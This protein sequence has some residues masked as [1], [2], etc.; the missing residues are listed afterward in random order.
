MSVR[1]SVRPSARNS[2][3]LIEQISM[4]F[5]I[6]VFFENLS[7]KFKFHQNRKRITV[8]SH[9]D[10]RT[11]MIKPHW[12]LFENRNLSDNICSWNQNIFYGR[13]SF[14]EIRDVYEIMCKTTVESDR[15]Q[16]I[17]WRMRIACWMTKATNTHLEYVT[18]IAFVQQQWLHKSSSMLRY[19]HAVSHFLSVLIAL[20]FNKT[21]RIKL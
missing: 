14:T 5:S 18:F 20:C 4:T 12:I 13:K 9:A 1:A 19:T 15:P 7:R 17:T 8:T 6:Q 11:L 10:P 21:K 2:S 16:M 3:I